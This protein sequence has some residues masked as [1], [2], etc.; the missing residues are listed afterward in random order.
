MGD[1]G[2]K[3]KDKAQKQKIA[4]QEQSAKEAE[5]NVPIKFPVLKTQ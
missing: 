3:D 1:K 4:K 5:E 2:K